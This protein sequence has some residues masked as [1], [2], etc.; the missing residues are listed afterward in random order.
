MDRS[1]WNLSTQVLLVLP[2]SKNKKDL[3]FGFKKSIEFLKISFSDVAFWEEGSLEAV[4]MQ[5]E[6]FAPK[7][8]WETQFEI[9]LM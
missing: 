3:L 8:N 9:F 6:R 4:T 7:K 2:V 1:S 5:F